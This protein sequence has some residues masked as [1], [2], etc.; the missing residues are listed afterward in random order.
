MPRKVRELAADYVRAGFQVVK[1]QGKGSHR[2]YRH[3]LLPGSFTLSGQDGADAKSYQEQDLR[4]ALQKV[5][6]A[7]KRKP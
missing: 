6:Q 2:K 4:D 7:R 5:A 3:P 1:N